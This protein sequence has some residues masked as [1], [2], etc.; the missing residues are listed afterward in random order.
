MKKLYMK[1]LGI[2]F[3]IAMA[4][5]MVIA[6]PTFAISPP[7]PDG[8]SADVDCDDPGVDNENPN[9][10]DTVLFY[11]TVHVDASSFN[12]KN[13]DDGY[14]CPMHSYYI[15]GAYANVFG[16]AYYTVYAPDGVTVVASGA[17]NWS[18]SE[19][20]DTGSIVIW[21]PIIINT[22]DENVS[23][24]ISEDWYWETSVLLDTVGDYVV[25]QGGE[26]SAEYGKWIQYGHYNWVGSGWCREWVFVPD[27]DPV[28]YAEGD[29]AY[30]ACFASRTVTALSNAPL[31]TGRTRPILTVLTPVDR[32]LFFTS[33]GWGDP[34]TDGI[35]HNDGIWQVEIADGTRILLDGEWHKKTWIEVDDQ[36]NVIGRYG[37]DG[38][39]IATEIGLSSPIKV[40]RVG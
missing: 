1:K 9:V 6:S 36:G 27:G 10:G 8:A 22:G 38:H 2:A 28:F 31:S 29:P 37:S 40:T 14:S 21:P 39:I 13:Y 32:E 12:N 35:V 24:S 17:A 26:A 11:G 20:G 7:D 3:A 25:E 18:D 30:D 23:A 34:T 19:E 33:D 4:A 5:L 16:N 15:T